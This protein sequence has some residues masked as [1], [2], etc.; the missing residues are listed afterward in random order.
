MGSQPQNR[1][2]IINGDEIII[3]ISETAG[4]IKQRLGLPQQHIVRAAR[5][6]KLD[7]LL[8]SQ[9][10]PADVTRLAIAPSFRYG[11]LY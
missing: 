8:D 9:V 1:T 2:I 3:A 6:N 10:V 7:E 5:T 11:G 4:Q